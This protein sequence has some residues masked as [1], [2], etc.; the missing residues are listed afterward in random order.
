[1][2]TSGRQVGQ[3]ASVGFQI[4]VRR[5]LPISQQQAWEYLTS[6]EGLR[7]WLGDLPG[8]QPE[9]RQSYTTAEGTTGQFRVVKP[10][11][12]LRLTWQPKGWLQ[13]SAVQIRLLPAS[14]HRTTIAFHQD[15]LANSDIRTEMRARWEE[16]LS[17]LEARLGG[18]G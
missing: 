15:R 9:A 11:E 6:P 2:T 17:A 12:Q 4:G 10:M 7:L 8:L 14:G 16:V 3:T 13:P 1:M 18:A 5:T